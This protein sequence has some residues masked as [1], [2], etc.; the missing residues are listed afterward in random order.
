[1]FDCFAWH[2][3]AFQ[4]FSNY[5]RLKEKVAF[6]FV[7]YRRVK[8]KQQGEIRFLEGVTPGYLSMEL[9]LALGNLILHIFNTALS[10]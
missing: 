9:I 7:S 1:M 4:F 6:V 5:V 10:F 3:S 2:S 8:D